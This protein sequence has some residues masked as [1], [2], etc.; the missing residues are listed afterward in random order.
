MERRDYLTVRKLKA[1]C[2][3]IIAKGHGDKAVFISSDDEGNGFH[4]LF[5]LFMTDKEDVEKFLNDTYSRNNDIP[6]DNI[7]ILG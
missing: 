4:E 7:V 3:D 6:V 1:A 2:D 5:F